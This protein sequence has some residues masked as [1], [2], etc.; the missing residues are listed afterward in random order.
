[1]N[2]DYYF[3]KAITSFD[4]EWFYLSCYEG[5]KYITWIDEVIELC[6]TLPINERSEKYKDIFLTEFDPKEL[7]DITRAKAFI[8]YKGN[9]YEAITVSVGFSEVILKARKGLEHEDLKIGFEDNINERMT[10][11][12]ITK[13]EIEDIRIEEVSVYD[14]MLEEYGNN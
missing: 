11:K 2:L 10:W 14:E 3:G 9:E 7:E 4:G 12:K 8:R 13:E 5:E 6:S 1:M